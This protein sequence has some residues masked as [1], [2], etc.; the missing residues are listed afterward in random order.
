MGNSTTTSCDLGSVELDECEFCDETLTLGGAATVKAGTLLARDS[1]SLKLVPFVVGGTT[2]NNGTPTAVLTYEVAA[3]GAGDI[4]V[5]ALVA[6][7]VRKERLIVHATGNGSGI[8][9][10]HLEA[11][12]DVEILALTSQQ[13]AG[14]AD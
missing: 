13:L 8:T 9:K 1:V 11:L 3:A 5:T 12:R 2:N 14:L 6:G 4:P 7:K 10:T